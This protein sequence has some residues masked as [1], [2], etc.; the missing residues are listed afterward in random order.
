ML[1]SLLSHKKEKRDKEKKFKKFKRS[2]YVLI[3]HIQEMSRSPFLNKLCTD[4]KQKRLVLWSAR[5]LKICAI[6]I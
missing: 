4:K 6:K 5:Q 1:S 2:N 3:R